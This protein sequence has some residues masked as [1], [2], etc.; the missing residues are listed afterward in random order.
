MTKAES[1]IHFD[2]VGN[3]AN[4]G[5]YLTIV[6]SIANFHEFREAQREVTKNTKLEYAGEKLAFRNG[7]YSETEE[8]WFLPFK[9][10][11]P[12]VVRRTQVHESYNYGKTP[13]Q[14]GA[15]FTFPTFFHLL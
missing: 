9:G 10:A 3:G 1:Y 7:G 11:D 5:T 15:Y 2:S 4:I 12:S 8:K 13:I 14:Y 6:H